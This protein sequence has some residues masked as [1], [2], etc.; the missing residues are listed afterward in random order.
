MA[1]NSAASSARSWRIW[2]LPERLAGTSPSSL[3][4]DP[5]CPP[6]H[7]C[8]PPLIWGKCRDTH[9]TRANPE[10]MSRAMEGWLARALGLA[11]AA[12]FLALLSLPSACAHRPEEA[13]GRLARK[14]GI[15]AD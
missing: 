4:T 3:S 12:L 2:R 13:G 9:E 6:P 1:T 8:L 11:A 5:R 14:P 10:R 7:G 15:P